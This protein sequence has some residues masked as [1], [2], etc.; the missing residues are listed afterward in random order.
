MTILRMTPEAEATG[1]IAEIYEA[2]R[3]SLGYVPSHTKAMSLNPEAF[4]AWESLTKAIS[5][6]LGLRRYELV[7]L[8]AA[9]AIGSS[10]CRLAHGKKTLKIIGE[11]QLHAIAKD[12]HN[13]GLSEA[14]VAMMDYAV[15][16]ST[17][18]ATM[19]D[20]DAQRLRDA[21]FSD[22]EIVDITMAAAAR[23]F[24]SRALLA[25]GVELDVPEGISE[26]LQS[27]LLTP[28]FPMRVPGVGGALSR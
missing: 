4:L 22:R 2:D 10:H 18:V 21:G 5:S 3:H 15:K 16:L 17:D 28:L 6:S 8:A 24:F 23:N 20:A 1:L 14:E 11:K 7:T 19:T 26:E 9:Q 27:A 25:M 12:F 13:A